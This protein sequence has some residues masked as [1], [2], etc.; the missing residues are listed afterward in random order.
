M[1]YLFIILIIFVCY[2]AELRIYF[3]LNGINKNKALIPFY[4][5]YIMCKKC[6]DKKWP[7]IMQLIL[8]IFQIICMSFAFIFM[9]MLYTYNSMSEYI[10]HSSG[11]TIKE[12]LNSTYLFCILFL[13]LLG[14]YGVIQLYVWKK[15]V[16]KNGLKNY[17][18]MLM[19]FIP[20][21]PL[22]TVN[23]KLY[24]KTKGEGVMKNYERSKH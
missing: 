23:A 20:F 13:I 8:N 7:F 2:K 24:E 12:L 19:L 21:I 4:S 22:K 10:I 16:K 17:N 5:K 3:H 9:F 14:I 18:G 6:T 15:F 1:Q 11:I